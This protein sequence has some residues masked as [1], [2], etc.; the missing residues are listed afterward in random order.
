MMKPKPAD[1]STI[2]MARI[3][4]KQNI[5]KQDGDKIASWL[6]TQKGVQHVLCNPQTKKV[7]FSFYPAK[8]NADNLTAA[9][10]S[11]LH[12][13]AVRYKPSEK[14]MM[15]SCPAM[16]SSFSYSIYNFINNTF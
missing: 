13:K 1:A 11:S 15:K 14:D 5:N 12:Y 7:V 8:V 3:D 16:S 2:A 9:L 4:V 10:S 6:Y